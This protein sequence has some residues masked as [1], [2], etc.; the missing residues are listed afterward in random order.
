[1][2][3]EVAKKYGTNVIS[4]AAFFVPVPDVASEVTL[5]GTKSTAAIIENTF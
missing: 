2:A 1:M 4:T 3:V 5:N